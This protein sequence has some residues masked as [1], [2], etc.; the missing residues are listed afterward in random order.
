MLPSYVITLIFIVI[1]RA[2]TAP[3]VKNRH[4][5]FVPRHSR[6]SLPITRIVFIVGIILLLAL[7]Q[8]SFR[9]TMFPDRDF[10]R[11]CDRLRL[12][13]NIGD[14]NIRWFGN[15]NRICYFLY[16][17]FFSSY[18]GT[19]PNLPSGFRLRLLSTPLPCFCFHMLS[20]NN[21]SRNITRLLLCGSLNFLTA[22]M[23]ILS[24]TNTNV[25]SAPNRTHTRWWH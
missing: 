6:L 13:C 18:G 20:N 25:S 15:L 19:R 22:L 17:N 24:Y 16:R 14:V 5:V 11:L 7:T 8:L 9:R 3:S 4:G 12:I 10:F 23:P 2:A 1:R 21:S